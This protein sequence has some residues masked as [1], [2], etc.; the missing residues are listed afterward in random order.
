MVID[1][2]RINYTPKALHKAGLRL[3]RSLMFER[4]DTER[5]IANHHLLQQQPGDVAHRK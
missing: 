3:R 2:G 4:E 5:R 1:T